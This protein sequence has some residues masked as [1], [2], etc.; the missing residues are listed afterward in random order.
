M[1]IRERPDD[2]LLLLAAAPRAWLDDGKKIR[3]ERAPT[4]YGTLNLSVESHSASG[5]IT[6]AIDMPSRK[7]PS[8]L[9][10]RFRHPQSLPIKAV[11]VNGRKWPGFDAQK[12]WV[13]IAN[14]GEK[15]YTIIA[16]Y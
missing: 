6:A 2:S 8:S 10:V 1:L 14:P 13:V 9:M 7:R 12:E 11:S 5:T 15:L 16:N 4:F 3:I